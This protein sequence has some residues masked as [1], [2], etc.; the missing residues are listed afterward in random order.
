MIKPPPVRLALRRD[1]GGVTL[2]V[3][4]TPKAARDEIVGIEIVGI[5]TFDGAAVL[6]ARVRALPADGRA[7]KALT[8]LVADWLDVAPSSVTVVLGGKSRLK[9]VRV[10][11][12]ASAL[13]TLI[14]AKLGEADDF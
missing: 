7:N 11:G 13:A 9:Q 8:K 10:Q 4:L 5:E 2:P 12:D 1:A 14:A 3:R 6:K